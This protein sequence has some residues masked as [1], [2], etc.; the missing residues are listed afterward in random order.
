MPHVHTGYASGMVPGARPSLLL[1]DLDGRSNYVT[2][3]PHHYVRSTNCLGC[4]DR[5]VASSGVTDPLR[6]SPEILPGLLA[7]T[8][9]M[10]ELLPQVRALGGI[11]PSMP[12]AIPPQVEAY[13]QARRLLP[14][15]AVAFY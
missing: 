10:L 14:P 7:Y 6:T 5:Q 3:R 1:P 12:A 8:S 15:L 4:A 9:C 13:C 11:L 2:C